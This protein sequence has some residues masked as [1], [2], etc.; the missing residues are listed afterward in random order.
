MPQPHSD[1]P[2]VIPIFDGHNDVLLRLVRK[3][4][5]DGGVRSFLEGDQ[6]G[7]IDLPRARSGG[8]AGGLFAVFVPSVVADGKMDEMM[9]AAEYD[10]PLPPAIELTPAQQTTVQTAALLLRIARQSEGQV[11][12]C[13]SA[14]DVRA[15]T[16]ANA[17]ATVLHIEGAEPIDAEFRML[18]VLYEAGLR[19]LGIVWSRPNIFGHG[20]PF[21]Y[22][23]SPD[24]GPGLTEAGRA[25]VAACNERR[26]LIDLSHLNEQGFRD[27]ASLSNAPLVATHSNAHAICPHS[28]NLIDRQL[29]AIRESG[30]L[31]GIN[32]A[33]CFL[34]PDGRTLADTS[35][36]EIVR[37]ADYLIDRL[38]IE[39]VGFG[40]DFD[41]ALIPE[42]IGSAAGLPKLLEV[43][44]A[45][46]YDEET[47]QKLCYE[48]WLSVLE[49]TWGA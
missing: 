24:T 29:A 21:R 34:R 42:E 19:S 48:N 39:G 49:R 14:S 32:F 38:G 40:S 3:A 25:L 7:H 27:V 41:G 4:E 46:G 35:L 37:H 33:A 44:R 31:V 9:Q 11:R 12:V 1:G 28:R 47:L 23:S 18:D 2:R 22:P 13:R 26:I 10:V 15:A 43:F 30:G 5:A 20:V 36:S 17:L 6:E 16:E 45:A 8:F